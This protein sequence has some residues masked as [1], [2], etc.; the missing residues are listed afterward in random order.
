MCWILL[1]VVDS[2]NGHFLSF[3]ILLSFFIKSNIQ[4]KV[5]EPTYRIG[6]EVSIMILIQKRFNKLLVLILNK[7]FHFIINFNLSLLIF[8]RWYQRYWY[9][10]Y[11]TEKYI[12]RIN[13]ILYKIL[14]KY[15]YWLYF[16]MSFKFSLF[17]FTVPLQFT[18]E[19]NLVYVRY[20]FHWLSLL[21]LLY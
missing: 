19:V 8:K 3:I 18:I 21:F 20:Y 12:I 10:N 9:N 15:Y 17:N 5:Y 7:D 1:I 6:L 14:K 16:I 2:F 4:F 13:E 11:L